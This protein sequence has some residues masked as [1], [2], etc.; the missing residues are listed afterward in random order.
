[1]KDINAGDKSLEKDL[2]VVRA[3]GFVPPI[4]RELEPGTDYP[5]RFC[6]EVEAIWQWMRKWF[7]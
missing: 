4:L 2:E 7:V 3:T 1:M 5:C 6:Q